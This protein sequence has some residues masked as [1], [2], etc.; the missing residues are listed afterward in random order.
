MTRRPRHDGEGAVHHVMNRGVNH[1]RIF[2]GDPDRFEFGERLNDIHEHFGVETLAYALMTNHY[3]LL[4]RTPDG[5]LP[6]AM[7][8]LGLVYVKRTN[9]RV[10]RDGPLFRAR[11]HS[12]RVTTDAYL[13]FATRYIHRNPLDLPGVDRADDYRWSSDRTYRDLRPSA[14]FMNTSIVLS[15]FGGDPRSMARFVDGDA[16]LAGAFRGVATVDDVKQLIQL[17]I[18][19]RELTAGVDECLPTWLERT[20]ILLIADAV[21]CSRLSEELVRGLDI[22]THGAQQKA[23]RRARERWDNTPVLR[24]LVVEVLSLIPPAQRAA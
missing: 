21:D 3:H 10:G 13:A 9:D 11:Y 8:R 16:D 22:P 23:L 12:I 6:D 19:V 24:S 7:H 15:L 2:F 17:G 4:L 14:P 5:G 20:A 18:G 1:Q